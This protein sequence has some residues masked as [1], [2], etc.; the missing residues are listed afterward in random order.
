MSE[1]VWFYVDRAQQRHGPV[2]TAAVAEAYAGGVID[3]NSLVWRE[4][5]GAWTALAGHR[6]ELGIAGP[7]SSPVMPQPAYPEPPRTSSK[8]LGCLIVGIVLLVGGVPILAI[9]AAIAIPAYQDYV[10]RAHS[11]SA[12]ADIRAHVPVVESFHAN[13]GRCPRDAA[14]VEV[15]TEVTTPDGRTTTITVGEDYAGRCQITGRIDGGNMMVNGTQLRLTREEN[16]Q[17]MCTGDVSLPKY[18]PSGCTPE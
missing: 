10:A 12:L 9:L 16:G 6:A 13:A 5:L 14:E 1:A 17:W 3:D 15:T 2:A 11:A 18:L 8:K 4:G 7:P